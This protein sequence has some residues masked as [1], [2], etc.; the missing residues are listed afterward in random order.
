MLLKLFIRYNDLQK[1]HAGEQIEAAVKDST[2]VIF[3]HSEV[4]VEVLVDSHEVIGRED[5]IS[6]GMQSGT[7]NKFLIKKN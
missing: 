1:Y 7:F 4:V 6:R 3:R 5:Y 2:N